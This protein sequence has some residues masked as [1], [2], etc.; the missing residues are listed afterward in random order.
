MTTK[1]FLKGEIGKETRY[2]T[3]DGVPKV[4]KHTFGIKVPIEIEKKLLSLPQ[5][6]RIKLMRRAIMR[7]VEQISN[8]N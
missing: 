6:E 8:C 5:K 2:K 4:G 7:E 1:E 3:M